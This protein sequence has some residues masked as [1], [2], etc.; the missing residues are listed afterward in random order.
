MTIAYFPKLYPDELLCSAVARYRVHTMAT[1]NAQVSREL[2]INH[3]RHT[4]IALPHNINLIHEKIGQFIGISALEL[5]HCSTL[6]P[7][8][9][10]FQSKKVRERML[11]VML[12]DQRRAIIN[13]GWNPRVKRVKICPDCMQADIAN[14]GEPYWHRTHQLDCIHF[15]GKHVCPL[16]QADTPLGQ[17]RS[18]EPLTASTPTITYL[19]YLS[20]LS[21]QRLFEMGHLA[22]SYLRR[23]KFTKKLPT[24]NVTPRG[25]QEIYSMVGGKLDMTRV[26]R[27]FVDY[28]GQQCLDLLEIP[29]DI[30]DAQ[31]WLKLSFIRFNTY[32]PIKCIAFEIF[33]KNYVL[34]RA[35][36]GRSLGYVQSTLSNRAWRCQN[37]AAEHFGQQVMT[38]VHIS[39]GFNTNKSI[40]FKCSC[41]Y[42]FH[43]KSSDWDRRTEPVPKRI[44]E[45][46]N[47]FI[48]LVRTLH[49]DGTS[50]GAISRKFNVNRDTIRRMLN[51]EYKTIKYKVCPEI[52]NSVSIAGRLR[53]ARRIALTGPSPEHDARDRD[54]AEHIYQTSRV[55]FEQRPPV[56]VSTRNVLMACA[57]PVETLI[58]EPYYPRALSAL[59]QVR[60]TAP[61]FYL[62]RRD[63][64]KNEKANVLSC[65]S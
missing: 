47:L 49:K 58:D 9:F 60:E 13:S 37:P 45:Y 35:K 63:L 51:P 15:C 16:L 24:V 2:Y 39:P 44:H 17:G 41:G 12:H 5:A 64:V 7:Y 43:V 3:N 31:S 1:A 46:G 8:Y 50:M 6:F 52:L 42:V 56:Q 4:S 18:L 20:E 27:D 33:H 32:I 10:A 19:P 28:F 11:D 40:T 38:D 54:L 59:N 57:I 53:K 22:E 62:R 30:D 25:F 26:R 48:E 65:S 21:K 34:A 55:L 36:H 23:T 61:D 29:V 14:Y